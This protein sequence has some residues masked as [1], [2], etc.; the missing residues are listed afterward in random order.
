MQLSIV[1]RA[2][3]P[4]FFVLMSALYGPRW[5]SARHSPLSHSGTVL[6]LNRHVIP[7]ACYVFGSETDVQSGRGTA[8]NFNTLLTA[9]AVTKR[10]CNSL[11][12]H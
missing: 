3:H 11:I 12:T 9:K 4:T 8:I 6:Y 10:Y 5:L 2:P 7:F 1:E